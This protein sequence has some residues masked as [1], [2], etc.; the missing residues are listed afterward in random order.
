M[1]ELTLRTVNVSLR[2]LP[3]CLM[4]VPERLFALLVAFD[5]PHHDLDGVTHAEVTGFL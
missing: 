1:P 5:D 3:F 4:T 2:P